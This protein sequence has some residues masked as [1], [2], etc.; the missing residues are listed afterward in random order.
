LD[1]SYLAL[2]DAV[3]LLALVE[4]AAETDLVA[5]VK[6]MFELR[7]ATAPA[8]QATLDEALARATAAV[9]AS[10]WRMRG[11]MASPVTGAHG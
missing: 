2:A 8:D 11:T 5:L 9:E 10:G 6:P 7:L 4:L 3:P 1:L